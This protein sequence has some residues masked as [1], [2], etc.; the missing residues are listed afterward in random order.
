MLAVWWQGDCF[1]FSV[2]A[3]VDSSAVFRGNGDRC[4]FTAASGE[5][6]F[7]TTAYQSGGPDSPAVQGHASPRSSRIFKDWT[8]QSAQKIQLCGRPELR[9]RITRRN[10]EGRHGIFADAR[11]HLRFVSRLKARPFVILSD[12]SGRQDL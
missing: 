12:P 7:E 2:G 11:H 3:D 5:I 10:A 6:Y 4:R 1:D 9:E 8:F